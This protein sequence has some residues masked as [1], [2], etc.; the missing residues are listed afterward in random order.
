MTWHRRLAKLSLAFGLLVL[1]TTT[2]SLAQP[3]GKSKDPFRKEVYVPSDVRA[4]ANEMR[5]GKR[6]FTTPSE[7]A[8]NEKDLDQLAQF[9]VF[10]LTHKEFYAAPEP[11]KNEIRPVSVDQTVHSLHYELD[12]YVIKMTATTKIT[13]DQAD[14]IKAFGASMDKAINT[15]LAMNNPDQIIRVNLGYML[16]NSCRSGAVAHA[17]T[18][19]KLM[20]DPKTKPDLLLSAIK[21]AENLIAAYDTFRLGT[22][23]YYKHTVDDVTLLEL[24]KELQK[25][26]AWEKPPFG[27]G[28]AGKKAVSSTPP[29]LP[30]AP[31]PVAPMA[32]P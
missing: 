6:P 2:I 23:D 15:V 16:V 5:E 22:S 25:V 24:V 19:L 14:Y 31:A 4:R 30:P 8:A 3:P 13:P 7:K 1:S 21:A 10:R 18:I 11:F 9:V 28:V 27:V 20:K 12:R 17:P 32:V 29:S 26:I